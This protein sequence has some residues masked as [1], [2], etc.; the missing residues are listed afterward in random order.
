MKRQ[1]NLLNCQSRDLLV[2]MLLLGGVAPHVFQFVKTAAFRQHDVND[3][4]YIVDQYPLHG[5]P[6]FM[7]IGK[8][9]AIFSHF[10]LYR[11]RYCFDLSSTAGFTNNKKIRH[12]FRYLSQIEGYDVMGFLFLYRLDDSFE[13]LRVPIQP[14][15]A[16]AFTGS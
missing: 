3:D 15:Y 7:L 12:R 14:D 4:I 1:N 9:I 13:D 2:F 11:I 16:A 8:L 6:A 5:G 10:L